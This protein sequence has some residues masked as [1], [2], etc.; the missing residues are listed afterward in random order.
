MEDLRISSLPRFPSRQARFS[1][2]Y[3]CA[4]S[5]DSMLT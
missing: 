5:M 4:P 3:G 2:R 1:L